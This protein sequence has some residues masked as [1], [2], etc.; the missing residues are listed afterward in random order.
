M[1]A[2]AGWL[3]GKLRNQLEGRIGVGEVVVAEL[4]A[5][6][7]LGPDEARPAPGGEF[8]NGGVLMRVLAVAKRLPELAR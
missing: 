3:A 5:L 4:L 2:M 7:Q 8:V 6:N 1:I